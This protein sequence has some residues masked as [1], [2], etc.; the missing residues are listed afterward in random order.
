M[1]ATEEPGA[2]SVFDPSSSKV[3]LRMKVLEEWINR[4]F[5]ASPLGIV[6]VN[7]DFKITYANKKAM[8][9]CGIESWDK[10]S[11]LEFV[12]DQS[13]MSLWREKLDNRLKGLS[14][15][16]ETEVVREPDHRRIPVR[17][18]AMPAMDPTGAVVGAV[19][20]IRT[21]EVE[22][23]SRSIEKCVQKSHTS[24]ALLESVAEQ[25]RRVIPF[26]VCSVTVYSA[27]TIHSRMLFTT[28]EELANQPSQRWFQMTPLL[29]LWAQHPQTVMVPD[30]VEF[31]QSMDLDQSYVRKTTENIRTLGLASFI[32]YPVVREGRV[33]GS[34]VL[35]SK[36]PNAYN[37]DHR[38]KLEALPLDIALG[39]ALH[40]EEV[41]ELEF[42]LGLVRDVLRCTDN[43]SIFSLLVNRLAAHYGW[44]SVS[45][46]RVNEER[47]TISLE[48]QMS[49][50]SDLIIPANYEQRID[51][52]VLGYVVRTGVEVSI[53]NVEK[54]TRFSKLFLRI[55]PL[56]VSELCMPIK[57]EG[58]VYALLNIEDSQ[59]NAFAPEEVDAL[60]LVLSEVE[61][62]IERF[63]NAQLINA[64]YNATPT[65]VWVI[66][67]RGKIRKANPAAERLIG[68]PEHQQVGTSLSKFF[69]D[70]E[71]GEAVLKAREPVSR[72]VT[73]L[74]KSGAPINVLLGGSQLLEKEF[75][76]ERIITVRDLRGHK[77]IEEIEL[78]DQLYYEIATQVKTPLALSC[79]WLQKLKSSVD[80][81]AQQVID[82]ALRQ[83]QKAE[84]TY[85]R[86]A[87]FDGSQAITPYHEV[88]LDLGR[89]LNACLNEF[90]KTDCE[91][92]ARQGLEAPAP[93]ILGD[94]FQLSFVFRSILS[95]LLRFGTESTQIRVEMS[96]GAAGITVT[97]LGPHAPP[98]SSRPLR[99]KSDEALVRTLSE[100]ALGEQVIKRFISNHKGK[101]YV[102]ELGPGC[103][104]FRIDLPLPAQG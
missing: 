4:Q 24:K 43:A 87:L 56:T 86:L 70:P 23:A 94:P 80:A 95:Y 7:L 76:G 90:P 5:D 55:S 36:K 12:P 93:L 61:T 92:I 18:A 63:R 60:K 16:Y 15:E 29:K 74:N 79:S 25:T 81:S 49:Q 39:T 59:E 11:I 17:V 26:D 37:D 42:R 82:K 34:F 91:G 50:S 52:G 8:E 38:R 100:M 41:Q 2:A 103:I 22:G 89:L 78:L 6:R 45:V 88:T 102:P 53:G 30:V 62:V 46:F 77:R 64:T 32:R 58:A 10:R 13:T 48:T 75:S 72:E 54:S 28:S 71:L 99:R 84:I 44:K 31:I 27:D 101:Y 67:A 33:I 3:F 1:A 20:F 83:L 21:L 97:I 96:T 35:S 51:E 98:D 40:Y 47:K 19:S 85:D 69:Q 14:E 73:L 68:I 9:I 57:V 104:K 66:D 65:S